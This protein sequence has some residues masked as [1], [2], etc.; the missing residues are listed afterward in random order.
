MN[1]LDLVLLVLI[2]GS[3]VVGIWIGL[4]R[5]A[6]GALGILVGV[7]TAGRMSED[8]G[9]LYASFVTNDTLATGVAYV[10]IILA[11]LI[12]ARVATIIARKV[13]YMLFMG[14]ID[15]AAGLA[16]GL[17]AGVVISG[18]AITGLAE[19]TYNSDLIGQGVI[20]GSLEDQVNAA[21][22]KETLEAAL[23]ES[24]FVDLFIDITVKL[25]VN[26][27][28]FV[29]GNVM[30]AVKSLDRRMDR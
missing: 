28:G 7:T 23:M 17:V 4:I 24:E 29:P 9:S 1:W 27:L 30:T 16:M 25:P 22:V 20:S 3:G 8:L 12:V 18:A 6:F 10:L 13:V 2:L 5:A 21:E 15:R 14:W 11:A 26:A 19:L